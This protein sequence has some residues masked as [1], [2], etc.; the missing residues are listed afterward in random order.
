[1][2]DDDKLFAWSLERYLLS[3]GIHTIAVSSGKRAVELAKKVKFD[4][5]FVDYQMPDMDGIAVAKT[6][7]DTDP[8]VKTIMISARQ[9][10][11]IPCEETLL[12]AYFNKPI[13]F[14]EMKRLLIGMKILNNGQ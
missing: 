11:E 14:S 3:Q 10:E 1:V 7:Q 8:E 6:I 2:V 13:D 5:L 9:R 12:A 4:L